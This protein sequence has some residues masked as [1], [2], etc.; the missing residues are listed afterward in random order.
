MF[1]L[2]FLVSIMSYRSLS[3]MKALLIHHKE[4]GYEHNASDVKNNLC[5]VTD[6]FCSSTSCLQILETVYLF[7]VFMILAVINMP[8]LNV[9]GSSFMH[10]CMLSPVVQHCTYRYLQCLISTLQHTQFC[11]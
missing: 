10:E 9:A 3:L 1:S 4:T 5:C 6:W 2:T 11:L 7:I 8:K